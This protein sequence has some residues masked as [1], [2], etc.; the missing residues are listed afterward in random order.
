MKQEKQLLLDDI[1]EQIQHSGGSFVIMS[2]TALNTNT[3]NQFRRAVAK[4]GGRVEVVPKRLLIKAAGFL[5]IPLAIE[6]LPGHV[7]LVFTGK[8]PIETA[9]LVFKFSAS[10]NSAIKAIGGRFDGQLYSGADVEQLSKL[11]NKDEMRAQLLAVFE[12]PMAQTLAVIDALLS[13]VIYCIDNKCKQGNPDEE[14][15]A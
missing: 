12:A 4:V 3:A 13:S 5:D 11:P 7:G 8:D 6:A 1:K 15:S 2:Y 14:P 10:S 9:K